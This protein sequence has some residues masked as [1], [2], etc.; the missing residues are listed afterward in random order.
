MVP[1]GLGSV[2]QSA[3]TG[4]ACAAA[5]RQDDQG[6]LRLSPGCSTGTVTL[7]FLRLDSLIAR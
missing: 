4:R 7:L 1:R 2:R 3:G 6:A 5:G